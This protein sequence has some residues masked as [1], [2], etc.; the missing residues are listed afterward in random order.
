VFIQ[1]YTLG[2][3]P[4]KTKDPLTLI[5]YLYMRSLKGSMGRSAVHKINREGRGKKQIAID[6]SSHG[7]VR[8]P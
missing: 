7:G 1:S 3:L 2:S 8:L 5:K 4:K 6:R